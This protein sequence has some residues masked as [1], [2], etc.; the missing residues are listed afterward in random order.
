MGGV[1]IDLN[2]EAARRAL[3]ALGCDISIFDLS[4]PLLVAFE[5]GQCSVHDFLTYMV[6]STE[7][8]VTIE[9]VSTIVALMVEGIP[10]YRVAM[11]K[12]LRT[13]YPLFLLSNT[14]RLHIDCINKHMHLDYGISTM[15]SLFEKAYYS[16]SLGKRKPDSAVFLEVIDDAGL[17]PQTTLMVDDN[18]DNIQVALSCG[19]QAL[20]IDLTQQDE[21]MRCLYQYLNF[22]E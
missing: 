14:N 17:V 2:F 19:L 16:F 15:D 6:Q 7:E 11:L 1:L 13:R 4:H 22:V 3:I 20:H 9:Q 18:Y 21:V 12:A 8:L 10:A 5:L